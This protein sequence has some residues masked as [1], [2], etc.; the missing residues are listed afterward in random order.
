M[1]KYQK[2][3]LI[4]DSEIQ[5]LHFFSPEAVDILQQFLAKDVSTKL[6]VKN[7]II[8]IY[9]KQPKKRLGSGSKGIEK[10][11]KHAFFKD[12][13]WQKL[14]EKKIQP[15]FVPKIDSEMDLSNIDRYFTREE[16]KETPTD[17]S[18]LLKKDKFDDFTYIDDNGFINRT[19]DHNK[20]NLD[21]DEDPDS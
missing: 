10:I 5:M 21:E 20:S 7:F 11:K 2:L 6:F 12:V 9:F 16:P 1:N 4:T 15:I 19:K 14:S 18:V 13:D 3:Q 8:N 17:D